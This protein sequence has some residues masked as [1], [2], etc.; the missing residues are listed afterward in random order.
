MSQYLVEVVIVRDP[1]ESNEFTVFIDGVKVDHHHETPEV[2]VVLWD[3]DLGSSEIDR[4][5]VHDNM[6]TMGVLSINAD[7]Y[8]KG[9]IRDTASARNIDMHLAW[10]AA[11]TDEPRDQLAD[12]RDIP[13]DATHAYYAVGPLGDGWSAQLVRT[14]RGKALPHL[15]VDL[16]KHKTEEAA[17][18]AAQTHEDNA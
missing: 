7:A 16:G 6:D 10:E 17:K 1:D 15:N 3:I 14:K 2:K 5:W 11:W 12:S 4:E 18:A 8:V 9:T 13:E